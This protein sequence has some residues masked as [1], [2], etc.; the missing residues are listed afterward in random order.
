MFTLINKDIANVKSD[1]N[2]L[3]IKI[4]LLRTHSS[5][6][7]DLELGPTTKFKRSTTQVHQQTIT[8]RIKQQYQID[9]RI[10]FSERC[11][12]SRI[13]RYQL[14]HVQLVTELTTSEN[15]SRIRLVD[16]S[17]QPGLTVQHKINPSTLS[18]CLLLCGLVALE[19]AVVVFC[20]QQL[21]VVRQ[22]SCLS[23]PLR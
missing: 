23:L 12:L 18:S 5:L 22:Q 14:R 15:S 10:E 16:C 7:A 8:N 2:L 19:E 6:G 1:Q 4:N 9:T 21:V 3:L 17:A 13:S 11:I 20:L